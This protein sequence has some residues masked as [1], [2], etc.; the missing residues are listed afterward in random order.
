MDASGWLIYLNQEFLSAPQRTCEFG[1][2]YTQ[3]YHGEVICV[4]YSS[5]FTHRP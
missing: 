3:E 4:S 1:V 2:G 5:F